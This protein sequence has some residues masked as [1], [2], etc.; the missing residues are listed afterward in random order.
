MDASELTVL[1][2]GPVA[3]LCRAQY[4]G[5]P[6]AVKVLPAKL[7]RRT[8]TAYHR[9]QAALPADAPILRPDALEQL[10]DGRHAVRMELC[11]Q[12]LTMLL[13]QIGTLAPADVLTLGHEIARALAAAHGAG[14]AHGGLTPDNVLFRASGQPVVADFGAALRGA[15]PRDL[16]RAIE[17]LPPEAIRSGTVDQHADLYALGAIMFLALTGAPPN[18]GR[19]GEPPGARVL[20]I[21]DEPVP[22]INRPDVPVPLAT[23]VARLLTADP[24]H[25]PSEAAVVADQL[26][27]LRAPALPQPPPVAELPVDVPEPDDF[28]DLAESED[29]AE[30]DVPEPV[31]H[32]VEV[33]RRR[34]QWIS[35]VRREHVLGFTAIALL[36]I[37][38]FV[39]LMPS[40]PTELD[41]SPHLPP[42]APANSGPASANPQQL[43]LA[44]PTDLGDHVVL[45]WTSSD[46]LDYAVI[47][48]EQGQP[49]RTLL[50]YRNRT[51]TVQVDPQNKYCFLVQGTNGSQVYQSAPQSLRGAVCHL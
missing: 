27:A 42:I 15:F 21:L 9:E 10:A 8:V 31:E 13:G 36:M 38:G 41:T 32:R 47:I 45:T 30:W 20:R 22:A 1:Y 12:S 48:A 4:A 29:V 6:V 25:R 39:L 37:V 33:G 51:M 3:T 2:Q 44:A 26:A 5:V 35:R 43:A 46:Q 16:M 40:S 28:Q 17:F 50:A 49:D 14:V 18:P 23:I 24:A 11:A 19:L 7:D 34:P